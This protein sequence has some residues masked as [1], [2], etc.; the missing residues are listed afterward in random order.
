MTTYLPLSRLLQRPQP[1]DQRHL[2]PRDLL[3]I[4]M[5]QDQDPTRIRELWMSQRSGTQIRYEICPGRSPVLYHDRVIYNIDVSQD[6]LLFLLCKNHVQHFSKP[7]NPHSADNRRSLYL[8]LS[9]LLF[10]I[11]IMS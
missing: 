9:F 2:P 10:P 3:A 5:K 8:G 11:C 6:G 4:V 1:L 7:A